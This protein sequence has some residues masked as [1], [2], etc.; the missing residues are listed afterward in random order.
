MTQDMKGK[1]KARVCRSLSCSTRRPRQQEHFS[2]ISS[3]EALSLKSESTLP[4]DDCLLKFC[5]IGQSLWPPKT[6][7]VRHW[8]HQ[9]GLLAPRHSTSNSAS[10]SADQ[11]DHSDSL[12]AVFYGKA[13]QLYAREANKE[14]LVKVWELHH[15]RCHCCSHKSC[16]AIK[17][18][19]VNSC[20]R[21]LCPDAVHDFTGFTTKIIKEIM[22]EMVDMAKKVGPGGSG[23]W[24]GGNG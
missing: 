4:I 12:H 1:D 21:K 24:R 9:S 10:R 3:T 7:G 17:P 19:T 5:Y 8:R 22:K 13:C 20:W 14:N 23:G 18:Q 2:R 15:P 11:K 6:L 16:D